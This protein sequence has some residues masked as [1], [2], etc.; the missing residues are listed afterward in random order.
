MID[1]KMQARGLR[2][3]QLTM[4]KM[5]LGSCAGVMAILAVAACAGTSS[6]ESDE[7][8]SVDSDTL[9]AQQSVTLT[10]SFGTWTLNSTAP[11]V[12]SQPACGPG[13]NITGGVIATTTGAAG[14]TRPFGVCL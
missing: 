2:G 8:A 7:V 14:S 6:E 13:G 10:D 5:L 11:V 4:K 12:T 9:S 1:H 3:R